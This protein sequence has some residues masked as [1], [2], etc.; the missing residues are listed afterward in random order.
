[1]KF[2]LLNV[3]TIVLLSRACRQRRLDN[4]PQREQNKGRS[5]PLKNGLAGYATLSGL[6]MT[7]SQFVKHVQGDLQ[8]RSH[9]IIKF[10]PLFQVDRAI[11]PG[12]GMK[13]E[14]N[15]ERR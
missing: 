8:A 14:D 5:K 1:M 9:E 11:M 12:C 15:Y 13:K 3:I 7:G 10:S 6:E 4:P 2:S